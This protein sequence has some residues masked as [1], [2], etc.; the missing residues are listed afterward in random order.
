MVFLLTTTNHNPS[1][2]VLLEKEHI[3]YLGRW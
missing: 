3:C 1:I 2:Y